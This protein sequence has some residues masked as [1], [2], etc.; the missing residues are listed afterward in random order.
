MQGEVIDK[1][2]MEV[3]MLGIMPVSL[4]EERWVVDKLINGIRVKSSEIKSVANKRG[5]HGRVKVFNFRNG[6][7]LEVPYQTRSNGAKVICPNEEGS[8]FVSNTNGVRI[9]V[10]ASGSD[11]DLGLY[12]HNSGIIRAESGSKAHVSE[13]YGTS[14]KG[15]VLADNTVMHSSKNL[16]VNAH[17]NTYGTF[18]NNSGDYPNTNVTLGGNIKQ[19]DYW[20]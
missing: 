15:R 2:R 16:Q 8:A 6:T 11:G 5:S 3:F 18:A 17:D 14:G 10:P 9:K 19:V 13:C 20:G 7:K 1:E 12:I 4:S